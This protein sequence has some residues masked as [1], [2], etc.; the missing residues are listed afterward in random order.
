MAKKKW[1]QRLPGY[2]TEDVTEGSSLKVL[3]E[4]KPTHSERERLYQR[5]RERARERNEQKMNVA[6]GGL[7]AYLAR[8][9][10]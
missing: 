8:D 2:A 1:H 3:P 4:E 9:Y 7:F 6:F 10:Y 5:A